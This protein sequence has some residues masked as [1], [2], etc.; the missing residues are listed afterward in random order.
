M[1]FRPK[2]VVIG[3]PKLLR[4][5]GMSL[6]LVL[7]CNSRSFVIDLSYSYLY[8]HDL[9]PDV[10]D[11]YFLICVCWHRFFPA[12]VNLVGKRVMENGPVLDWKEE[13]KTL[14]L[15]AIWATQLMEPDGAKERVGGAT[16][17]NYLLDF[18]SFVLE[19]FVSWFANCNLTISLTGSRFR[20]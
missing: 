12:C 20:L 14:V 2:V 5:S 19:K 8:L 6:S 3:S 16:L 10:S 7:L 13:K 9:Y 17:A 4:S 11:I 1:E 15:W 18:V